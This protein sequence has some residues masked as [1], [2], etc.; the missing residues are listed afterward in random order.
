MGVVCSKGITM[1][2]E[3]GKI[4]R[5]ERDEPVV[6]VSN[7]SHT[8]IVEGP[9]FYYISASDKVLVTARRLVLGDNAL[10]FPLPSKVE[11]AG[12]SP[13]KVGQ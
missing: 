10:R 5:I 1:G 2:I 12:L 4:I 3:I 11:V 13:N 9:G 6:R 7:R 8:R